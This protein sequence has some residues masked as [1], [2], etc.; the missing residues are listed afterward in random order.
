[1][2]ILTKLNSLK[3]MVFTGSLIIGILG[4][5]V[6]GQEQSDQRQLLTDNWLLKS[7]VLVPEDGTRIST[8][9]YKPQ[10]WFRISVPTTVLNALVKNGI[11]PDP[12]IGLN[13]L[14]IPDSSDEFNL[15]NDLS[16]YSYLPD[17]RNPWRD[18][19]WYR[20]E[21]MLD[22]WPKEKHLWLEFKGINYRADVW[23]NGKQVADSNTMAGIYQRFRFDITDYARKGANCLA[24]KIHPVDHPGEPDL[25][26]TPGVYSRRFSGKELQ[27]DVTYTMSIGYDCMP[28]IPDRNMGIWREACLDWTG[29]VDI[30][31]PFIG[32]DLPL[33]D[34]SRATLS[35]SVELV[36]A[37]RST[38]NGVLSG[39]ITDTDVHF[40]QQVQ[41]AP[42]ET[43]LVCLE[44]KLVMEQPRLWWP[45]N[46]GRQHL[47]QMKLEF[48]IMKT[49]TSERATANMS[50]TEMVTFGVRK[51]TRELHWFNDSPGLRIHVNGQKV[52]SQG[53]WLQPELLFDMPAERMEAEVRYLI[54]A[55]L[56]TVTVEDLPFLTDEFLNAC[57]R[58]G[59]MFWMSFYSSYWIGPERNWPLD[60]TLLN[61]GGV[62][63]IKQ[64]RNHPSLLLYSC[65]GEGEPGEDIYQAWRRNLLA[66]DCTR[67]FIPTIDT[68]KKHKWYEQDLPTGT[69]D[70]VAFWDIS[71]SGYYQRVRDGKKWMFNTEVGMASLPPVSSLTKFIPD[72]LSK[73][74]KPGTELYP[75]DAV[76]AHHDASAFIKDFD[77]AIRLYYGTPH[78]V[79]DYIWKAQLLS[80]ERHRAWSE[81]VSHRMWN[82]TSGLWEWKINSCWPSVGWQIYDWYLK[83]MVSSYY[84]KCA[85]ELLHIQLSPLDGMVT[86]VNRCLQPVSN[87]E[88]YASVYDSNMNLRWENRTA[89]SIGANTY[90]DAF[91]IP[92]LRHLTPVYFVKLRLNR[93][94]KSVSENFYWLSAK[95]YANDD[96]EAPPSG[97]FNMFSSFNLFSVANTADF[98]ALTELP[99]V[100]LNVEQQIEAKGDNR[101]VSVNV[102]NPTDQLAFFIQ[103]AV[104]RGPQGEEVLPVFWK[105]NYFS[106]LP[107]ETREV[108]ATFASK[109][110]NGTKPTVEAGGWNIET[111]CRCTKIAASKNTVKP[112]ETFTVTAGMANTFLDGS[113]VALLVDG[114][115]VNTQWAYARG[116]N[117]DE[118]TFAVNLLQEGKHV[119]TIAD[120]SITLDVK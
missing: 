119:L 74:N 112:G 117:S 109:D 63:V 82:I 101:V 48:D 103:L 93:D 15:K 105:D 98:S 14:R 92:L 49:R 36:N 97:D 54:G 8:V 23:I 51:V 13:S 58:L 65:V 16:K 33:P 69:H 67:L 20:T 35:V 37:S 102:K 116:S 4:P 7:S 32:P 84:Y 55:N 106:L 50:D 19:Y 42:N 110:L 12:R 17:K 1:M 114:K 27:K 21:F 3:N 120:R 72:L 60:H 47:Y 66:I 115:S 78:T 62:D 118:I 95:P 11:Y 88:V 34:T 43:K 57:D 28:T 104:T 64:H 77:P 70:A 41:L 5:V 45:V 9:D 75:Q 94:G 25:Q 76:W 59:L 6:N 53:G 107:G 85:F 73:K 111:G 113:R 38:V 99:M 86:I 24:V 44:P 40:E 52:F 87:L 68:R 89:S 39:R 18:P 96:H 46:Y 90:R 91:S 26:L 56:N 108:T 29:P 10:Q 30:R 2:K 100:K 83:P 79:V 61:K 22:D 80:A 31:D 81:A 71:P